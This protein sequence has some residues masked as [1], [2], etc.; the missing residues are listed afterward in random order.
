MRARLWWTA[1]TP[2]ASRSGAGSYAL[3]PPVRAPFGVAR[4]REPLSPACRVFLDILRETCAARSA[5]GPGP[6]A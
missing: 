5:D 2:S 1:G 3:G 4:R 6:A